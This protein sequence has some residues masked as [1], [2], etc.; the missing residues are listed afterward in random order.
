MLCRIRLRVCHR[1]YRGLVGDVT[2]GTVTDLDGNFQLTGVPKNATISI[3]YIGYQTVELPANSP[4]LANVVLTEDSQ[5][6]DEL[7]VVGYGTMKKKDLM[8]AA[9]ALSGDNLTTNSNISVGGALQGKMSGINVMS[10]TGFPGAETNISIR[11]IGTFGSG[12]NSPLIVI[13]GSPVSSGIEMLNPN[14]I[15]SVNVLKDASSAAIYGS[16]AANGVILITTK[17]GVEGKA[18]LSVNANWG[19]SVPLTSRTCSRPKSLSPLFWRCA[20]IKSH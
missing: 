5:L 14:D 17:K 18:K 3:S 6:L 19:F 1:R 7:V 12:D 16:R 13:D 20:T 10:S 2:K 9:S 8:G 15:E 4:Q 11:G